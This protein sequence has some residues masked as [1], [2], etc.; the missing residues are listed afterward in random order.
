ML[1]A[2]VPAEHAISAWQDWWIETNC[3]CGSRFYP[4]KWIADRYGRD[5][6]VSDAAR[7][8]VCKECGTQP[9]ACLVS[10]PK[11][12]AGNTAR[13]QQKIRRVTLPLTK[14]PERLVEQ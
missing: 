5:F 8:L 1:K 9:R 3:D 14:Q 4:C 7:R 10:E 13:D 2:P 12:T 6:D 11:A